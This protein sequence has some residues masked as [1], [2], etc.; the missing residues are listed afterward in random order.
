M[1]IRFLFGAFLALSL[2][3]GAQAGTIQDF[4]DGLDPSDSFFDF[5][6]AAIYGDCANLNSCSKVETNAEG[7]GVT[8]ST[9]TA[10]RQLYRDNKDGFGIKGNENDEIDSDEV[11]TVAFDGGWQP[12]FLGLTDLFLPNDGGA[13]GE[14]AIVRG[15]RN[16]AL[17]Y[18]LRLLG[19]FDLGVGNGE[20]IFDLPGLPVDFLE[21]HS[22]ENPNLTFFQLDGISVGQSNDEYSV[23]FIAGVA[24]DAPEPGVL[25]LMG[26][27][28]LGLGLMRRRR[29]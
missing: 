7:R 11:L 8:I 4:I 12:T 13:D 15:F 29:G 18:E 9:D 3:G 1:F 16:N 24:V 5:R 14:E 2:A 19:Q 17:V 22:V 6:N 28:L 25:A 23:A 27:G 26:F 10:N 20:R 21:F